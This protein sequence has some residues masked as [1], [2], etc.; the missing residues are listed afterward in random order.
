MRNQRQ[1]IEKTFFKVVSS[2]VREKR[3]HFDVRSLRKGE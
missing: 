3:G 1:T 2:F